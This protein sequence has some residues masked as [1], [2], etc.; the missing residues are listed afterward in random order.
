MRPSA[1][2]VQRYRVALEWERQRLL[3]VLGERKIA[4]M[5]ARA[6]LEAMGAAR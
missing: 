1:G 3:R 6:I 2:A 4:L 5:Y